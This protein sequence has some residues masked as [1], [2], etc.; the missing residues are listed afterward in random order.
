MSQTLAG[1]TQY[2]KIFFDT[3]LGANGQT[4]ANALL[5]VCDRDYAVLQRIFGGIT[6]RALPFN[7]YVTTGNNGASNDGYST[8]SVGANSA[9]GPSGWNTPWFPIWNN[10]PMQPG[11]TVTALW[12]SNET[13]LDQIPLDL[14][15]KRQTF[16][17][18]EVISLLI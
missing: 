6:P 8:I 18:A 12:R 9:L 14:V 16:D 10:T 2:F 7:V 1:T 3:D 13:H 17:I 15:V 5:E 11:A 4:V